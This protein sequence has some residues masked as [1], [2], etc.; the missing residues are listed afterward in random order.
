MRS[1]L[2]AI[3]LAVAAGAL[4]CGAAAQPGAGWPTK[5]VKLIVPFPAGG[6]TDAIP[7]ILSDK[8]SAK[9]GQPV[10]VDNRPGAAG[11]TGADQVY[12]AEPD[13]HTL[14]VSAPGPLVVAP[15][16][17]RKLPFDPQRFVPISMLATM[18]N[19]LATRPTLPASSMQEFITMAK[20]EPGKY[21]FASQGVGTTSHLSAAMFQQMTG[22]E[23]LHVPYK[24]T[25]PALADLMGGQVDIIFDNVTSS[26][27]AYKAGRIKVLAVTTP[28]RLDALPG[29]PTAEE[30]GLKGFLSSTFVAMLAPPGTPPALAARI[31]RDVAEAVRQPDVQKRFVDLGAEPVGGS[32]DELAKF[33]ANDTAR[34]R[35]VIQR[36]NVQVD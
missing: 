8:L 1:Q 29:V 24:G 26:L 28:K 14:L 31:Q 13:G 19:L 4:A 7:R 32:Q 17:S 35:G 33:L 16:L 34:W 21:S 20:R 15:S 30:A 22:T 25:A 12:R 6:T 5:P 18:P 36:A 3:I 27:Q 2:K 23:L 9:W 10:V 11:N